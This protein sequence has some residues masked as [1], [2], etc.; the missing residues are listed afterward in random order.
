[1]YNGNQYNGPSMVMPANYAPV[2]EPPQKRSH[3]GLILI[4]VAILII[5]AIITVAIVIFANDN[6]FHRD[7]EQIT[8]DSSDE[9]TGGGKESIPKNE[10]L[11][12]LKDYSISNEDIQKIEMEVFNKLNAHYGERSFD[13]VVY[14]IKNIKKTTT[15][16]SFTFTT[17]LQDKTFYVDLTLNNNSVEAIAIN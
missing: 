12:F 17:N 9:E 1:M 14:D 15:R 13:Y 4:I 5:G 6:D 8:Y 2:P 16:I 11:D 10:T 7:A 3:K